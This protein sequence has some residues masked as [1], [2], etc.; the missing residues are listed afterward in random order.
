MEF[1][2]IPGGSL[3]K[4]TD[5]S[6]SESTQILCQLSSALE[7]LHNQ[8]PSIGHRDIKPE[9]ILVVERA[10]DG[11]RVK[12]GD[13]GLSKATDTLKTCCGTARFAAPEIY[14]KM[15]DARGTADNTYSVA[16]DI[17]SLGVVIASL[18]CGGLPVYKDE[19]IT[20]AFTWIRAIEN[21]VVETY[22]MQGGELLWLLIDSMLVEDPDERSSADYIHDEAL[23]IL[24]SMASNESDDDDEEEGSATPKPS[25][26][27]AQP[28]VGSVDAEEASTF[29]L[30]G[31]P[32]L[33]GSRTSIRETV[34]SPDES[35]IENCGN[36]SPTDSE[37]EA[38]E[39][40]NAPSPETQLSLVPG[41]FRPL[42]LGSTVDG[43]LWNPEGP[44]RA[45]LTSN[46][47]NEAGELN[48]VEHN[49][50]DH[51]F[52]LVQYGLGEEVQGDGAGA[53]DAP[54]GRRPMRKRTWAENNSPFSLPRSS[55]HPLSSV[56]QRRT[57]GIGSSAHKRSKRE[58]RVRKN[59]ESRP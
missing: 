7:Y 58:G 51:V 50:E 25:M 40:L 11:I 16:V 20:D 43:L 2:Y 59:V 10:A 5:V 18:V 29:R 46:H 49:K 54:G 31:Q 56:E 6:A 52:F 1:E 8:K 24:Q 30:H 34:E 35:L 14:L 42:L 27:T 26:L 32:V 21:H 13:F 45:S 47:D 33:D 15:A 55:T 57:I 41:G 53:V 3:E 17:W 22:N 44:E 37:E 9:N 36:A 4:Y 48:T 23:R 28:S 19:W 12:F 39:W 38:R